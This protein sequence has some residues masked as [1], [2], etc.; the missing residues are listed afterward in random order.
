MITIANISIL[1]TGYPNITNDGEQESTTNMA[2]A[3]EEIELKSVEMNYD[4]SAGLDT[5][6]SIGKYYSSTE[7]AQTEINFASVDNPTIVINGVLNRTSSTDMD[8]IP[9]LDKLVTT[10]GIK[11]VYYN[12]TTDGYRDL[13]DSIGSTDTYHLSN[14]TKHL[15]VRVK[16][17]SI[18]HT[19]NTLLL[20]FTLT[21]EVTA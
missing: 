15:H 7:I 20:R 2:N 9:E 5:G 12:S 14:G 11:I 16:S 19:T 13:T 10:K 3:G 18:R 21:C 17:F 8:M 6:P 4:R 1:D